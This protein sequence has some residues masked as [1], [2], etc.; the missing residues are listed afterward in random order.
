MS[1]ARFGWSRCPGCGGGLEPLRSA[2][3]GVGDAHGTLST[4]ERVPPLSVCG[5][6]F[7]VWFDWWAGETSALSR[8]LV[9]LP[10]GGSATPGQGHCPRDGMPLEPHAYLDQG[11]VVRRCG[12]CMGL[13][14]GRA[15]I[16]ELAAFA[17]KLPDQPDHPGPIEDPT[18]L[19]RL[20]RLLR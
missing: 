5:A 2:D 3:L 16:D 12:R 10:R 7:G 18:V 17:E 19:A 4:S 9:E 15:Q 11:P 20:W 14:A 1:E 8:A 13:F 6:C